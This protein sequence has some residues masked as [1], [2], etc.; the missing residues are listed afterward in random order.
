MP[1]MRRNDFPEPESIHDEITRRASEAHEVVPHD[2]IDPQ[3]AEILREKTKNIANAE[4]RRLGRAILEEPNLDSLQELAELAGISEE[5]IAEKAVA[6]LELMAQAASGSKEL[7]PR[8]RTAIAKIASGLVRKKGEEGITSQQVLNLIRINLKAGFPPYSGY[9]HKYPELS[10]IYRHANRIDAN[11]EINYGKVEKGNAFYGTGSFQG[12]LQQRLGVKTPESFTYTDERGKTRTYYRNILP[13]EYVEKAMEKALQGTPM[14]ES[15]WRHKD[16]QGRTLDPELYNIYSRIKGTKIEGN[17]FMGHGSWNAFLEHRLHLQPLPKITYQGREYRTTPIGYTRK[18]P[19]KR[20]RIRIE[21][22][23]ELREKYGSLFQAALPLLHPGVRRVATEFHG[24]D[25]Q[26]PK[27]FAKIKGFKRNGL[28]ASLTY[29]AGLCALENLKLPNEETTQEHLNNFAKYIFP[30]LDP[31]QK[32]FL[33]KQTST[34]LPHYKET[35]ERRVGTEGSEMYRM[36]LLMKLAGFPKTTFRVLK[37][38]GTMNAV[39]IMDE[40]AS[41]SGEEQAKQYGNRMK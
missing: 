27:P 15:Y 26:T 29:L 25:G 16:K 4:L 10:S 23:G 31:V 35:A 36:N 38:Q 32:R 14:H 39:K 28:S 13:Q 30:H 6:A 18:T 11:G 21:N 20:P 41:L 2:H 22:Q 3:A 5:G 40:L 24:L 34:P 37:G 33:L 9:W 17:S 8:V 1:K 12:L 19:V 7:H